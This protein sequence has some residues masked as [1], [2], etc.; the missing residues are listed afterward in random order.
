MLYHSRTLCVKGL[1]DPVFINKELL[2]DK[3]EV[4]Q[5]FETLNYNADSKKKLT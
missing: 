5:F 4:S 2:G 1:S 3:Y